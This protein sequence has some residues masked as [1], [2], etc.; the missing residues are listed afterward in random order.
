MPAFEKG[1]KLY[2]TI[3]QV[4]GAGSGHFTVVVIENNGNVHM[5]NTMGVISERLANDD[6]Y[7]Y[8]MPKLV[9]ALNAHKDPAAP[10]VFKATT[11]VRTGIQDA[12]ALSNSC[13]IYSF[14][15]WAVLMMTQDINA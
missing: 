8:I 7:L 11:N 3:I 6:P 2:A 10:I 13:G 15:Y 1:Q 5:I 12:D 14:V 4:G 9:E